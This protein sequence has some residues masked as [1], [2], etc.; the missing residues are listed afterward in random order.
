MESENARAEQRRQ[1]ESQVASLQTTIKDKTVETDKWKSKAE[2]VV[3]NLASSLEEKEKQLGKISEL[4]QVVAKANEK[5]QTLIQEGQKKV[6]LDRISFPY[7]QLFNLVLFLDE[8]I[9][10]KYLEIFSLLC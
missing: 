3:A 4:E 1:L 2:D 10:K 8:H 5:V 9:E 6:R 7:L